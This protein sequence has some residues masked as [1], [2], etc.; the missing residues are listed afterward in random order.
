[1][2]VR[3]GGE[4]LQS[5]AVDRGSVACMVGSADGRTLFLVVREWRGIES[6]AERARTGQVFTRTRPHRTQGGLEGVGRAE[7]VE[8]STQG[9]GKLMTLPECNSG[10]FYTLRPDMGRARALD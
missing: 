6:T 1:M 2:R 8:G 5:V 10:S 9:P 3:E 4:V 7:T